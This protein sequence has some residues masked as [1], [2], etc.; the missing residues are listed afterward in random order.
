MSKQVS[1]VGLNNQRTGSNDSQG[2]ETR[3][4]QIEMAI[5][6]VKAK[7]TADR[8]EKRETAYKEKL[9]VTAVTEVAEIMK[10]ACETFNPKSSVEYTLKCND[11]WRCTLEFK[12][13]PDKLESDY[14]GSTDPITCEFKLYAHDERG[15][16]NFH[17]TAHSFQGPRVST[18]P[19][20][21]TV[22]ALLFCEKW[23]DVMASI[24]EEPNDDGLDA[25]TS[26]SN[27]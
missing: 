14:F 7:V 2:T 6:M 9:L 25:M 15:D 4:S 8:E 22:E 12:L 27:L 19:S 20:D 16:N 1:Q 26:I 17:L 23:I 11:C 3:Q 10:E 5:R 24:S 18:Q 13:Y 21:F